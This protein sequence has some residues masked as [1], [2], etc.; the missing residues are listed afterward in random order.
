[1]AT[2]PLW[3]S[4]CFTEITVSQSIFSFLIKTDFHQKY[5]KKIINI[6]STIHT[7]SLRNFIIKILSCPCE[8]VHFLSYYM[9]LQTHNS[10]ARADRQQGSGKPAGICLSIATQKFWHTH[11]HLKIWRGDGTTEMQKTTSNPT[12]AITEEAALPPPVRR[13]SWGNAAHST[14]APQPRVKA[15]GKQLVTSSL[16]AVTTA[17]VKL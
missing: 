2:L 16:F 11:Q 8:V 5:L 10:C 4:R 14:H 9:D 1:M 17:A 3:G 6:Y 13:E 12:F 7:R 15:N